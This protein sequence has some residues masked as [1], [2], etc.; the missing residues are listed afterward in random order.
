MCH[1]AGFLH[2][3]DHLGEPLYNLAVPCD[4]YV[5]SAKAYLE[6]KPYALAHGAS[7]Q[8][9][10]FENF[11]LSA[12]T[13]P[14][15]DLVKAWVDPRA[16]FIWLI[17]YGGTGNG[18][19]HLCNAALTV[20]LHRGQQARLVTASALL[21]S[22]RRAMADHT[23][24]DVMASYQ[25]VAELIIDDMGAGMKHPSEKGSEWEWARIEELLV[26]RYDALLPTMATTN[27]DLAELPERIVSRFGDMACSRMVQNKAPDY[28]LGS[29]RRRSEQRTASDD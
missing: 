22:L 11:L 20:L 5:K 7:P 19:S 4:C 10:T 9:Q 6:G 18:K 15:F 29:Q 17:I 21:A 27:L 12:S 3:L 26:S 1:G 16:D 13:R 28:R 24:D 8:G 23:T 14:I 2:P 25:N